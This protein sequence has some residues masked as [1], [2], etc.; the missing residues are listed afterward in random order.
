MDTTL[1]NCFLFPISF[2][3]IILF[4]LS[5]YPNIWEDNFT[6]YIPIFFLLLTSFIYFVL[7]FILMIWYFKQQYLI[8]F[9][10]HL[11]AIIC[12]PVVWFKYYYLIKYLL[13][14]LFY[15]LSTP[16]LNISI[17]NRNNGINN[18]FSKT[19]NIIFFFT[20]TIVRIIFG[21][22]LLFITIPKIYQLEYPYNYFI[23]FP[24]ILQLMVYLWYYK[25]IMMMRKNFLTR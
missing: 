22:F 24:I 19:I 15:E 12:I 14:Y 5:S 18:F 23:F 3:S 4:N 16:F 2:G 10:H 21:T 11:L 17:N 7:D 13:A 8:Y 6:Y 25:I 1:A 20:Y 9:I